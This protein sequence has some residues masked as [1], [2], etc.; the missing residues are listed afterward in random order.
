MLDKEFHSKSE[1][2]RRQKHK[3]DATEKN[4]CMKKGPKNMHMELVLILVF[5]HK[6]RPAAR[7]RKEMI[8]PVTANTV[9][10]RRTRPMGQRNVLTIK[11]NKI[12]ELTSKNIL[13]QRV[14]ITY[15]RS[16]CTPREIIE[17]LEGHGF[18]A[19]L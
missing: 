14:K 13:T 3:Q 5:P 7:R 4:F 16:K 6:I 18:S 17:K 15:D 12:E 11:L 1:V 19:E 9:D 10:C 8:D 2:T